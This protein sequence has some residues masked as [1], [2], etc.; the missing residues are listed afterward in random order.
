MAWQSRRNE[1][2]HREAKEE[3]CKS[4]KREFGGEKERVGVVCERACHEFRSGIGLEEEVVDLSGNEIEHWCEVSV[5]AC[6]YTIC[7]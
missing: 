3:Q 4:G 2:M 5:C 6:S 1:K 7:D